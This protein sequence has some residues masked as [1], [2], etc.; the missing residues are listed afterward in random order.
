[1]LAIL[2]VPPILAGTYAGIE[3]VEGR[4]VPVGELDITHSSVR[5]VIDAGVGYIPEDR[6]KDGLVGDFTI[7]ENVM[8]NRSYG[9]PFA[10]GLQVDFAS[11]DRIA[12]QLIKD[13][14]VR[15]P[16]IDVTASALSGGNQQKLIVGR[17]MKI[18]KLP[19]DISRD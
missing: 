19:F 6:S 10:K 9:P 18:A 2:A 5:E 16:S 17:E 15:T 3:Q 11:R 4:P 12:D 7:A 8:I 13:Y 14:D 1:M